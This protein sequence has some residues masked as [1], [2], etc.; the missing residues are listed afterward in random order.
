[1]GVYKKQ[2]K[3]ISCLIISDI[4]K[5]MFY[6]RQ[7]Y[8]TVLSD[9]TGMFT[10]AY[11]LTEQQLR[12][13]ARTTLIRILHDYSAFNVS[14]IDHFFQQTVRAFVREIGLPG[15]YRIEMD[16]D[17]VLSEA[18]DGFFRSRLSPRRWRPAGPRPWCWAVPTRTWRISHSI[19]S[20]PGIS[21][22]M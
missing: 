16:R 8:I 15:N 1:M 22:S 19:F 12:S 4:E 17:L 7:K 6:Y 5:L 9:Y 3:K 14:T 21:V 10:E 2:P 13:C 18:I 11:R 20:P